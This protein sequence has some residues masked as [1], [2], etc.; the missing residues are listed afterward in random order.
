MKSLKLIF[1][2]SIPDPIDYE[3]TRWWN[4]PY[5]HGSYSYDCVGGSSSDFDELGKSIENRLLFAGEAT[6]SRG[7]A[8]V[9]GAY[10]SGERAA[11]ELFNN[12]NK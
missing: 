10:L 2:N 8:F 5:S 11:K 3:I 9:N 7:H 12:I 1:G 6:I 4:D